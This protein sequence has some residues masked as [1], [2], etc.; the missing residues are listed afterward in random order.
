MTIVVSILLSPCK[1]ER[2]G[3]SKIGSSGPFVSM[4]RI[5]STTIHV[6]REVVALHCRVG[7][8]LTWMYV[9][10]VE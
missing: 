3:D 6:R 5:N 8:S 10:N 4:S 2:T 1:A 9:Q 7:C